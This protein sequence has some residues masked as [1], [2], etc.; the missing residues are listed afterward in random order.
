MLSHLGFARRLVRAHSSPAKLELL[1]KP[2]GL[3]VAA[4]DLQSLDFAPDT[5]N[6]KPSKSP[7]LLQL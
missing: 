2:Q 6:P 3:E 7:A 4:G 5:L 1:V